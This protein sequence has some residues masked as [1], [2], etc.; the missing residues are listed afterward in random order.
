MP[1][2]CKK[3][4]PAAARRAARLS[5]AATRAATRAANKASKACPPGGCKKVQP[6]KQHGKKA[7][8]GGGGKKDKPCVCGKIKNKAT[9][10]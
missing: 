2:C 1:N 4:S 6:K 8:K 3:P 10:G 5:R 9:G 7:G